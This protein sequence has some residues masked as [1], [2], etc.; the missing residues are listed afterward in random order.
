M[1]VV[2]VL[3]AVVRAGSGLGT[4]MVAVNPMDTTQMAPIY[5]MGPTYKQIEVGL[6]ED[7]ASCSK[8]SY[9]FMLAHASQLRSNGL[10]CVPRQV[11]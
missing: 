7:Q 3:I 8:A 10:S 11:Q 5:S 6:Y 9:D 2:W 4:G 1:H